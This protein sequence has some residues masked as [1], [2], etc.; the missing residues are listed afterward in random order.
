MGQNAT[1]KIDR[2]RVEVTYIDD[3]FIYAFDKENPDSDTLQIKH[4]IS[5]VNAEFNATIAALQKGCQLNLIDVSI[6]ENGVLLP[7]IVIFEPDYLLDISSLAECMK[8]YGKSPL[9]FFRSKFEPVKNSKHIILGNIANVFLDEI[10]N[11]DHEN[12]VTYNDSIKKAFKASPFEISVCNDLNDTFFRETQSHFKNIRNVVRNVFPA[13]GIETEHAMIEPSFIC[14][15]LGVQGRLDF[16]Q[17][18]SASG[19][20]FVIELKS[21]KA[22]FPETN[23]TTIGLNHRS[24]A[25]I[26]QIIIQKILGVQ[27]KDLSTYI[28]YSKY[29]DPNAGMRLAKPYMSA[30]KEILNIRNLIVA[31]EKIIAFD[32]NEIQTRNIINSISPKTLVTDKPLTDNFIQQWIAPQI[33]EFASCF[34]SASTLELD[35]FYGFYTFVTR[36]H[37]LSKVSNAD[38]DRFR[39]ISSLWL[40]SLDEKLESG[41]IMTDLTIIE[42]RSGCSD[43]CVSLEIPKYE[44]FFLPNFRQG[45]IVIL[46]E[47]NSEKDNV[48]NRQIFKGSIERLTPDKITVRLRFRQRNPEA[49]PANSRYAIEHDFLDSSFNAMYRGL[50]AFLQAN[51]DRKNLLLAQRSPEAEVTLKLSGNYL[52]KEINQIVLKAKQSKDYFLLIGPPGTGKTSIALKSMVEEFYSEPDSNILLMAFTN[53]AVDEIC[54]ALDNLRGNPPYIRVGTELSCDEKH[55]KRMLENVI[56]HCKNREEVKDLIQ[57]HRIFVGTTASISNKSELFTLKSFQVAIIDEAS[58]IL[59][60][61]II[62]VLTAKDANGRNAI[63]KFILIGDYKQLPAVVLQTEEESKVTKSSLLQIGLKNKNISLFQR[64]FGL[65]QSDSDSPFWD[66]L[67]KQGRMHPDIAE[68]PNRYFYNNCL[69]IAET[70]HQISDLP[71]KTYDENDAMQTIAATKRLAFFKSVSDK[72]NKNIKSNASEAGIVKNL[73][74]AIFDLYKVNNLHFSP[75]KSVGIITPYRSQIALIKREIHDLN[76]VELNEITVDTVERFQGSQRDIII[77]SFCINRL[78]QLVF[79][80][81]IIYDG[82]QMIDRKLNVAITRAKKQFFVTGNPVYLS[83]NQIFKRFIEK[84][85]TV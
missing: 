49:L 19:R 80:A 14:E 17:L 30:I 85:P 12:P 51:S 34:H 26:Y 64:L 45:D 15:Q 36:E 55:R 44:Q 22:P 56:E 1:Y 73:V 60:P 76:I 9:N 6:D 79:L 43:C 67:H 37:Y 40:S 42:N 54:D 13:K 57:N 83:K 52:N 65:H 2:I 35:Y 10:V 77:Y 84:T 20:K 53:R 82:E 48:T 3:E 18:K 31:N 41:E 62:E 63:S 4:N 27:F 16:L 74:K 25:F 21:G 81:N 38:H 50:Y 78:D 5:G 72:N 23:I 71:Y 68:F 32:E 39:G 61:G 59:E 24:Q 66:L 29:S 47:R 28:F 58:Q 69:E 70:Q 46:Y 33:D 11:E 7:E 8:D 75:E